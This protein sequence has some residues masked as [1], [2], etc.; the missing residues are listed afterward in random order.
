MTETQ[1]DVFIEA[2]ETA[3]VEQYKVVRAQVGGDPPTLAELIKC[4]TRGTYEGV[5]ESALHLTPEQYAILMKHV[6]KAK[7]YAKGNQGKTKRRKS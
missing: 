2:G 6:K 7:K 1:M 5:L 4:V 3:I